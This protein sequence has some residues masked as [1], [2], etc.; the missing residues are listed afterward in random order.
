MG[1]KSF[2]AP[3]RQDFKILDNKEV[4]G[5]LRVK[6]SNIMWKSKDAKKWK[7]VSMEKFAE[8]AKEH[9]TDASQ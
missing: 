7:K 1:K 2:S 6:A 9:G 5:T 3:A 4:F 8:L